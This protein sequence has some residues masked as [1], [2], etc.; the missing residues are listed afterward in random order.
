AGHKATRGGEPFDERADWRDVAEAQAD[1]AD[2]A[3]TKPHEP[4]LM[5]V[6]AERADQQAAAPAQRRDKTGLARPDALEPATP[7]GRGNAEQQ[8]E[9]REHPAEVELAPVAVR[10]KQRLQ[11]AG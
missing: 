4:K 10:G 5:D 8:E 7:D 2:H 11:R 6:D 1:A 9:E 3:G